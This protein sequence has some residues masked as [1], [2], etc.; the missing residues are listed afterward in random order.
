M[1]RETTRQTDGHVVPVALSKLRLDR[2]VWPRHALDHE[3]VAQFASLYEEGG[4]AVLPPVEAVRAKDLLLS[5]GVTRKAGATLARLTELPTI[6]VEPPEGID[7]VLFAYLRAIA[8]STRG[9]KQLSRAEVHAAI[10]RLIAETELRDDQIAPLVGVA[11]VTVWRHRQRLTGSS[12]EQSPAD[13]GE[14]YFALATA[15][16]V[17]TRLFKGLEKVYSARGLGV[18]D[19]LTGDHT[20]ERLGRVLADAY[21]DDALAQARRFRGWIDD[22]I[23]S[24]AKRGRR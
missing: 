21:G 8:A 6:V 9:A 20:G 13:A 24:L 17:A 4:P 1:Q 11:R 19:A 2:R 22:A 23:A 10:R 14:A 7:P 16:Q 18:W 12:D 3:R 5:D 15:H